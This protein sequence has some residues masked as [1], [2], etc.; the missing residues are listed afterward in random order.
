MKFSASR[1]G[2]WIAC[3]RKA[4]WKYIAGYPEGEGDA[5]ARGKRVH[6][7]LENLKRKGILPDRSTEDGAIAAEAL[8]HVEDLV[9]EGENGPV[10]LE[11]EYGVK[12][13]HEWVLIRDIMGPGHVRDYKTTSDFK[14]AKTE[15]ELLS[16][17]QA[18]LYA[19]EYFSV[20]PGEDT[21]TLT[22]IYLRTKEPYGS[23]IVQVVMTRRHATAGFEVLERF[24]DRM[25][26]AAE[27][28][29]ED[30]TER[31]KYILTLAP[32]ESRCKDY[33]GCPYR[34][35]CTD[36]KPFK[37][38]T[39]PI[40]ERNN[41]M[42]LLDEL[43]AMLAEDGPKEVRVDNV[44]D[45]ATAVLGL[46]GHPVPANPTPGGNPMSS[47][48]ADMPP[49]TT[50]AVNP[51]KKERKPRQPK[52]VAT[53]TVPAPPPT[54]PETPEAK[55]AAPATVVNNV[56]VVQ[57]TVAP[58]A[59][60]AALLAEAE[61][62]IM[63]AADQARIARDREEGPKPTPRFHIE[64]L[65]VG[66]ILRGS[67]EPTPEA[68]DFDS[69]VAKARDLI[70]PASYFGDYGY[71]TNGR[72]LEHITRIIES[73]HITNLVVIDPRTPEATLCLSMLRAKSG[74]IVESVRQ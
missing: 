21:V 36:L 68:V 52:P 70:G 28:A 15:A 62:P 59:E 54:Q 73:G 56:T 47:E 66:C 60:L 11:A 38:P 14:W 51:P 25:Q 22:W 46:A 50:Q 4:G 45:A 57:T 8:P 12:C 74:V 13:R 63:A 30:I 40:N 37:D 71:K 29:P 67:I 7:I 69:L 10:Q 44:A 3:N 33:R 23:H 39:D 64:V 18:I 65:C 17:P 35:H 27:A 16:D 53:D 55:D 48:R 58:S 19:Y 41:H 26:A 5:Q 24:A 32:N 20:H 9:Y 49:A 6:K 43:S 31:H 34:R 2:L 42:S 72:L 61:E 1:I